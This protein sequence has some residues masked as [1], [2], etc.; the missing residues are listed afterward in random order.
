MY[1]SAPLGRAQETTQQTL[2]K[3]EPYFTMF[4]VAKKSAATVGGVQDLLLC[5]CW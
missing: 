2:N 1:P 4:I 3:S 5:F